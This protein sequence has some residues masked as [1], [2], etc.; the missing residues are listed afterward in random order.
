MTDDDGFM[1]MEVILKTGVDAVMLVL[2]TCLST[3]A[4][5]MC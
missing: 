3:G 4:E 5:R 1:M 2:L